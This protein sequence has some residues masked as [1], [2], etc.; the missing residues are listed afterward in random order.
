MLQETCDLR[1]EISALRK[2][3]D[4]KLEKLKAQIKEMREEGDKQSLKVMIL[5][6]E[7]D[8]ALSKAKEL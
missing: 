4:R 1:D 6:T 5:T 8:T 2:R 7:R 3:H